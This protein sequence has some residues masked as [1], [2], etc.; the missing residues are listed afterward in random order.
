MSSRKSQAGR[1]GMMLIF[2]LMLAAP[3]A[4]ARPAV[5]LEICQIQGSGFSTPYQGQAVTTQGVVTADL[6]ETSQR[7]FFMQTANCDG[8]PS[9]SDG[10]FIYLGE[11]LDV[12]SAGELVQVSGTAQEYYGMT[13]IATTGASVTVL[14][15]GNPL[16]AAQELSP[17][18][19]NNAARA[20]FESLE[21]MYASLGQGRVVGPTDSDD[22]TWLVRDDLGIERVF[23][24][25]PAGTGEVICADDGGLFE[26]AP[27][28]KSGDLATGLLGALD[29]RYAVY[30]MELTAPPLL[31]PARF[32]ASLS[33]RLAAAAPAFEVASFNLANLFD[34]VND[35]DTDD[36]V[37]SASEY[38]RRLQKRA[39]AI[40]DFLGEPAL[41]AV[42]EAEN[43]GVLQDLAGQPE[44]Q[45]AY[46][47]IL[48]DGPDRR[49]LDVAL[50][51][52]SDQAQVLA[53]QARQGCT[54]L[55][56]G[57]G[58]DGNLDVYN[59]QN[60]ITCD[61]DGD[62]ILD[63]N[64][65]FSRPPLVVEVEICP[66]G[67]GGEPV[68]LVLVINHWKSKTEDSSST[69]YTLP[70]RIQQAQ[71][72]AALAQELGAAHPDHYLLVLGDLNDYP[73]SQ[74]LAIL[75]SQGLDNLLLD[76]PK[77]EQYTY[78][79]HGLSQV[80]DH[81]LTPDQPQPL[82]L[83]ISIA[84][85]NAD[86][87]TA[88]ATQNGTPYRSSDHDPLL[89]RFTLATQASYLPLVLAGP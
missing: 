82:P 64:R 84:H 77:P 5:F 32:S 41:L 63:G 80:L 29:F 75:A 60:D 11:K 72:V 61:S 56:D 53:Y 30:C 39:L 78:I 27:E 16:P 47:A 59:P 69:Q 1:L 3:L 58:P 83:A 7:G 6:D 74:P 18:F 62:H 55:V 24:D 65:L 12:V 79:Y 44:I 33:P 87:P 13:E 20:Y 21:G 67:C 2:G 50:L 70:R 51:Y 35:P 49:G 52:R 28:A 10:I 43:L 38:Q 73:N 34:T 88:T 45:S 37:L 54:T 40:H 86:F 22:R 36:S 57:L 26:I 8:N 9:T 15:G 48:V 76:V 89:L 46:S 31:V 25:D 19:D 4:Q 14:S 81:I 71:F 17:P 66:P 42:Q 23:H 68:A 85:I